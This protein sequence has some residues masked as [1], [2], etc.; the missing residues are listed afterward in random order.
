MQ[1]Q[2]APLDMDPGVDT[3][4][5]QAGKGRRTPGLTV[6]PPPGLCLTEGADVHVA[7]PSSFPHSNLITAKGAQYA[8]PCWRR[9]GLN[10]RRSHPVDF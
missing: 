1:N 10:I 4:L 7:H 5:R 6:S 8:V 2:W 9:A 3:S